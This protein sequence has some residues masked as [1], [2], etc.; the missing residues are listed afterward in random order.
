MRNRRFR[1]GQ[2]VMWVWPSKVTVQARIIH[3][4]SDGTAYVSCT[5][6]YF[7]VPLSEL[8]H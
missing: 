7:T 3:L 8:R 1:E 4:M 2:R 6:G 5:S